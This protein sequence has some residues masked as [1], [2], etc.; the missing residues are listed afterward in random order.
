MQLFTSSNAAAGSSADGKRLRV[1]RRASNDWQRLSPSF[2]FIDLLEPSRKNR[3]HIGESARRTLTPVNTHF[4]I[5]VFILWWFHCCSGKWEKTGAACFLFLPHTCTHRN[6]C[7][8]AQKNNTLESEPGGDLQHIE[9]KL[10]ISWDAAAGDTLA[11]K[12]FSLGSEK[13]DQDILFWRKCH[14]ALWS[15]SKS[16]K[17]TSVDVQRGDA[18][19]VRRVGAIVPEH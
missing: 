16:A 18:T 9:G 1:P 11:I 13:P 17:E 7:R 12:S 19:S 15:Y 10:N 8:N 3:A 4:I 5:M 6:M 14:A 2:C